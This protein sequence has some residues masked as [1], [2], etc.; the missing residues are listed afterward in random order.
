MPSR[1]SECTLLPS[2]AD[3]H[4]P[5]IPFSTESP[6]SL[7]SLIPRAISSRI[8]SVT[9]IRVGGN[10][11]EINIYHSPEDNTAAT[12]VVPKILYR[13]TQNDS[14]RLLPILGVTIVFHGPPSILQISR[15]LG[16]KWTVARDAL[17]PISAE[18]GLARPDSPIGFLSNINLP[19]CLRDFLLERSRRLWIDPATYHS[20]LARWCLTGQQTLDSHDI[21]CSGDFWAYQTYYPNPSAQL[22]GALR[23]WWIPLDQC[24][25]RS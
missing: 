13:R 6:P 4:P 23:T 19:R 21:I 25:T 7:P 17:R 5:L 22:Y 11:H 20:I 15:D 1:P 9:N 14:Q 3:P 24:R 18:L 12:P 8:E 2:P 10:Y 16:L